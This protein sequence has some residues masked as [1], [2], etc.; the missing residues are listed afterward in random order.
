MLILIAIFFT[1][2]LVGFLIGVFFCAILVSNRGV[3]I[4]NETEQNNKPTL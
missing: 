4:Q 3:Q 1:G 2:T